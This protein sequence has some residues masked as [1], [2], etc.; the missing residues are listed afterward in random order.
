VEA[1]FSL[2]TIILKPSPTPGV[3]EMSRQP[4]T[5][6]DL[7]HSTVSE[8]EYQMERLAFGEG[9]FKKASSYVVNTYQFMKSGTPRDVTA[10]VN[11]ILL[12]IKDIEKTLQDDANKQRYDLLFAKQDALVKMYAELHSIIQYHTKQP[13]LPPAPGRGQAHPGYHPPAPQQAYNPPPGHHFFHSTTQPQPSAPMQPHPPPTQRRQPF[14]R[15]ATAFIRRN[16]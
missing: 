12:E 6:H 9:G 14:S 13:Q 10:A 15:R 1:G 7:Q 2:C 11:K 4:Q 3:S 8:E 16:P 5:Y